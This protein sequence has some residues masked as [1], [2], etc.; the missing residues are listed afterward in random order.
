[1]AKPTKFT[2]EVS[3]P[4]LQVGLGIAIEEIENATSIDKFGYNPSVGNAFE[5][6]WDVGGVYAYPSSAVPM[7]VTS[8]Y[9]TPASDNG[10]QVTVIGLDENWAEVSDTV[11]LAGVGTATT[12]QEFLRVYRA[13]V[14][15]GQEPLDDI[16]ISNDSVTYAQITY[17]YNQTL[18][19]VYTVPAG[20]KAYVVAGNVSSLKDKEITAKLMVRQENGV[21]QTKG[22]VLT[23]GAPFARTWVVP[24]AIPE[25]SDIE[26]RA[27]AGATGPVA[28]GLEFI[29]V[30]H[31]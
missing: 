9:S 30:D 1:M 27:K 11:T 5:T 13:Y 28:A 21:F 4:S 29:L 25:K 24:Q 14:N 12:T 16:V 2:S 6:I 3:K 15:N 17:P 18:M 22:L 20:Y 31:T 26:I 7:T 10:V 23:P 19:M 8:Q